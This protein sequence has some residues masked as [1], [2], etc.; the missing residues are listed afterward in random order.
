MPIHELHQNKKADFHNNMFVCNCHLLLEVGGTKTNTI[1]ETRVAVSLV[2][3]PTMLALVGK[4]KSL[5]ERQVAL[6]SGWRS[7]LG[8]VA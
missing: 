8:L 1:I 5:Y 3:G 6:A 4:I 7:S 2:N